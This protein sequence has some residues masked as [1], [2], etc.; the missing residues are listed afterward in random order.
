M[1]AH[2]SKDFHLRVLHIV[3]ERVDENEFCHDPRPRFR[4]AIGEMIPDVRL[5]CGNQ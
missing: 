3:A 4:F 1:M 5:L 2:E